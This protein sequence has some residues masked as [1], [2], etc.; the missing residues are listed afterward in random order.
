MKTFKVLPKFV[1]VHVEFYAQTQK[2]EDLK[3]KKY[4][5]GPFLYQ[6]GAWGKKRILTDYCF[7]LIN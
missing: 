2:L 6:I 7:L 5:V 4:K 3:D 1:Y